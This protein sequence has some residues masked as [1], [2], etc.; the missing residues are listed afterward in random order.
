MRLS[1]PP[2]SVAA[3]ETVQREYRGTPNYEGVSQ[4]TVGGME[5]R[6]TARPVVPRRAR[7]G[8]GSSIGSMLSTVAVV[9]EGI[10]RTDAL[11]GSMNRE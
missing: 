6:E 5:R 3:F 11:Y 10:Y 7:G 8:S 2:S 9:G 1:Y 4:Y